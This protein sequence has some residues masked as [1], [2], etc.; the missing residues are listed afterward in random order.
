[1]RNKNE[2]HRDIKLAIETTR[3]IIGVMEDMKITTLERA[4]GMTTVILALI[5]KVRA[6]EKGGSH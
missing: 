1:M 3:L 6:Q 4:D 5:L 2:R